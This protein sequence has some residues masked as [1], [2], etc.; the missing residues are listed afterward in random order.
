MGVADQIVASWFSSIDLSN[1]AEQEHK[2]EQQNI[3][4]ILT[5]FSSNFIFLTLPS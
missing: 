3:L 5:L 4:F 1:K 2:N